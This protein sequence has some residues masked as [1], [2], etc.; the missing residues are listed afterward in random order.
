M[1]GSELHLFRII[2]DVKRNFMRK[3]SYL[4]CFL[5]S[6]VGIYHAQ[7]PTLYGMQATSPGSVDIFTFESF[8]PISCSSTIIAENIPIPTLPSFLSGISSSCEEIFYPGSDQNGNKG[9]LKYNLSSGLPLLTLINS[10]F[11]ETKPMEFEY[12]FNNQLLFSFSYD[13][14]NH[15]YY[16]YIDENSGNETVLFE[17]PDTVFNEQG[18]WSAGSQF[19]NNMT[20]DMGNSMVYHLF[21]YNLLTKYDINSNS[22]QKISAQQF[23]TS[24]MFFVYNIFFDSG[25]NCIYGIGNN[26]P[27]GFGLLKLDL[28]T[29]QFSLVTEINE[30]V[31]NL[32]YATYSDEYNLY[33][34]SINI[35]LTDSNYTITY[36]LNNNLESLCNYGQ[37]D[38]PMIYIDCA[39]VGIER[40]MM[41]KELIIVPNPVTHKLYVSDETEAPT[42]IDLSDLSGRNLLSKMNTHEI[43]LSNF[44]SGTYH[45]SILIN[46]NKFNRKIIKL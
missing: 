46:G 19:N 29:N 11:P 38:P 17:I 15:L 20:L 34:V 28:V 18:G 22:F 42:Q 24:N 37:L 26:P 4:I 9:I 31:D 16:S 39:D 33:T 10:P 41:E 7:T 45:I 44:P 21:N 23:N 30:N 40:K 1:N 8:N 27:S 13:H 2:F 35:P 6:F 12:N 32:N 3:I 43:D 36:D 14:I 25:D 5:S